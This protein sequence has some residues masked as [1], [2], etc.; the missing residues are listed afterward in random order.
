MTGPGT[1]T[2]WLKG[3]DDGYDAAKFGTDE[4]DMTYTGN[5]AYGTGFNAGWDKFMWELAE[6]LELA[7]F[8][9]DATANV[10]ELDALH[11]AVEAEV[12]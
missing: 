6:L 1:P 5:D 10:A 9:T 2:D 12:A 8:P 4:Y 3:W 7:Y 11:A